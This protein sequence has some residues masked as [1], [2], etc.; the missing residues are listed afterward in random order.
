MKIAFLTSSRS[1]FGIYLP[2][3]K[4]MTNDPAFDVRIIAFGTHLS[5]FHGYTIDSI[6]AEGF[7]IDHSIETVMTSDSAAA[8]A[9]SMALT[10]MKFAAIWEQEKNNYDLVF[11]LGD[12]YEMFAAVSASI[13]FNI[14]FAHMHGGET[15]LGAIDNQ[16]RHC[17]SIFSTLHFVATEEYAEKVKNLVEDASNIY[18]V[19]ALSLDNLQT[20]DLLNPKEFFEKFNIDIN[21]P[22]I[23][24]TYHPETV[25]LKSNKSNALQLTEALK[26][27]KDY[28]I[29]ITMP[30]ADTSGNKLRHIYAAFANENSNVYIVENFGTQGYFSCLHNCKLVV[31][32]S[33]SGIIEAASFKKYVVDIGARQKGRATSG[34]VIHCNADVESIRLACQKGLNKKEYPGGNIYFKG[35]ATKKIIG[36]LKNGN[37]RKV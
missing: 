32:N 17:L 37:I 11:C 1:D 35:G 28:Q 7:T 9:T 5:S 12:R 6:L 26:H 31:G 21:K 3:L 4:A 25:D 2:L 33:S 27:F 8:I 10:T 34:N 16:F 24:V 20:I 29:I 30:N 19:G 18:P 13:P 15:T 36:V 14:S 23:L 22:S